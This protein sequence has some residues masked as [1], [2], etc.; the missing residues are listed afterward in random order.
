[1][2]YSI[3][4]LSVGT[5]DIPG[6]PSN[7]SLNLVN[8]YLFQTAPV[9]IGE[10]TLDVVYN[11]DAPQ[12]APLVLNYFIVLNRTSDTREAPTATSTSTAQ[13]DTAFTMT[14]TAQTSSSIGNVSDG[15]LNAKGASPRSYSH[16][17]IAAVA[18][19]GCV[20][21]IALSMFIFIIH[22]RRGRFRHGNWYNWT[23]RY[24]LDQDGRD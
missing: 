1:M 22:R 17:G 23:Y 19:G 16:G 6:S 14:T 9:P 24:P 11:G 4:G 20:A 3:D 7:A 10:H 13:S 8:Q 2:A 18:V 12:S 15:A 5:A 21:L